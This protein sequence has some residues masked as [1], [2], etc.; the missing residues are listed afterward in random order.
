M[1]TKTYRPYKK[2]IRELR[3]IMAELVEMIN[4]EIEK[5]SELSKSKKGANQQKLF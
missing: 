1:N 3:H 4:D 5:T 2:K